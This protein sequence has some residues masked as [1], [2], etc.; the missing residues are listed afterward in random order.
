MNRA[1][2]VDIQP[3]RQGQKPH[4]GGAPALNKD[5]EHRDDD[6]QPVF[7]WKTLI[8]ESKAHK[9]LLLSLTPLKVIPCLIADV[10]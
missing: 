4:V 5:T 2:K 3:P 9:Q 1:M 10:C 8:P 6:H 7:K